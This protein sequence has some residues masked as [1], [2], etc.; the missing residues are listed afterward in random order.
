MLRSSSKYYS[1]LAI[2]IFD[3]EMAI[4]H[5]KNCKM[6]EAKYNIDMS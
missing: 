5:A 2:M 6:N 3:L 4:Y 1:Q